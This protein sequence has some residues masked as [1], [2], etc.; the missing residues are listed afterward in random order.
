MS[1]RH[2][3]LAILTAE[4]MTG[5]DLV[6]YFDGSV[7]FVWNAPHSQIYPQL[8]RME[9]EGLVE[10]EIL[11]RGRRAEKR[12]YRI[13]QRGIAEL[14]RW[15][16]EVAPLPP[17]RST[18][19]LKA[20]FM[21]WAEP[22]AGRRQLREHIAH[23]EAWL[24]RWRQ[25]VDD[26]DAERVPL[27]RTRVERLPEEQREAVVA[28]KRFAFEGEIARAEAEI[29]WARRGLKLLDRLEAARGEAA[30]FPP[31]EIGM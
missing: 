14:E 21:E 16:R 15:V 11:P 1:L 2:A 4:P 13:G 6:K 26:I 3:L 23:Y 9:E 31:A 24:G 19:R 30:W 7:A 10:V 22:E 17:T 20:A 25:M 12:R 18:A 27:L 28:Y 5:Y 29:A 8:R